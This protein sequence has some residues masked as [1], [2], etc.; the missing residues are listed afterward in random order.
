MKSKR[1]STA[2]PKP[3]Q[4]RGLAALVPGEV[5]D[6]TSL[7]REL[8][9]EIQRMSRNATELLLKN[10]KY[11]E[12]RAVMRHGWPSQLFKHLEKIARKAK[13]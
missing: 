7:P 13:L 1:E 8:Q 4:G 10:M 2:K 3:S 11:D 6:K 12:A 5:A 9:A